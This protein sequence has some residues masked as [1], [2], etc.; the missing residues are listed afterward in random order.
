[1]LSTSQARVKRNSS[2]TTAEPAAAA[3]PSQRLLGKLKRNMIPHTSKRNRALETKAK[4]KP[5]LSFN[6]PLRMTTCIFQ[7]PVSRITSHSGT[8]VRCSQWEEKLK[9]PQ[10][11]CAYRRL[12]G[13]QACSSSGEP[14]DTLTFTDIIKIVP[15]G[16]DEFLVCDC[17]GGPCPHPKPT[18]GYSSNMAEITPGVNLRFSQSFR[19]LL[20]TPVDIRRQ[21]LKVK[22]ARERLTLALRA[23][24]FIREV[25]RAKSLAEHLKTR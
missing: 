3:F 4:W 20:V 21:T 15:G 24:S 12:E 25:E 2:E 13:L 1:M 19:G 8:E 5:A 22:K 6:T 11:V 18:S 23:D 9:K 16:P 7:K 14:L 10:Q 17:N